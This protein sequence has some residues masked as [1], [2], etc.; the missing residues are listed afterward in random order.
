M[1]QAVALFKSARFRLSSSISIFLV[2]VFTT[3]RTSI[4][5]LIPQS[6]PRQIA[7]SAPINQQESVGARYICFL[8]FERKARGA[9][10]KGVKLVFC[11]IESEDSGRS[12]THM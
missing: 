8:L 3:M 12:R 5:L 11:N 10:K 2:R 9:R 6:K 1:K 4:S 7:H